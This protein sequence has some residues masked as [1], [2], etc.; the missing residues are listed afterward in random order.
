MALAFHPK[1]GNGSALE[2]NWSELVG[3]VELAQGYRVTHVSQIINMTSAIF[4]QISLP[5]L[6]TD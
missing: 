2:I 5:M 1:L 4:Y 6:R 3:H